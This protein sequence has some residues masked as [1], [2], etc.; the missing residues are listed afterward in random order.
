MDSWLRKELQHSFC[1]QLVHLR[2]VETCAVAAR[3]ERAPT[4]VVHSLPNVM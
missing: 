1:D 3:C 4:F 2:A